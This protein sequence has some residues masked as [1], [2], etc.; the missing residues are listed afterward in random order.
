[1]A[2]E[3]YPELEI[4]KRAS[5]VL[6]SGSPR[7]RELLGRIVP[8]SQFQVISADLDETVLEG[9]TAEEYVRRL[10]LEKAEAV[11]RL[12]PGRNIGLAKKKQEWL[13]LGADTTVVV[14]QQVLGKPDSLKDVARMMRLL[15]ART[16]RV[17]T[18]VAV[19]EMKDGH[20]VSRRETFTTTT[21]VEFKALAP[22]EIEW[23]VNTGEPMGKAGA[24][25]VQGYG[26]LFITSI[27]GDF[28][29]IVGLPVAPLV[30]LLKSF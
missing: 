23:Y 29:N 12:L 11:A 19:L 9:E 10:A 14:D 15:S 18:G 4:L 20:S 25:A 22:A 21:S 16:H 27:Q 2:Y 26:G 3:V 24:Y 6:A 30:N 1:M 17:I 8:D 5:L 13:V 28:Y 7:R